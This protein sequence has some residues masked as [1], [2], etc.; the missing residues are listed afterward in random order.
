[1]STINEVLFG[2]LSS[3]SG[4]AALLAANGIT[5]I[6]HQ[7]PPQNPTF[8]YVTYQI[9]SGAPDYHLNG[10]TTLFRNR[11]EINVWAK[12]SKSVT[13]VNIAIR[14]SLTAVRG[15]VN[16][17]LVYGVF[18]ERESDFYESDLKIFRISTDYFFHYKEQML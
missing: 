13:D 5:R 7:V 14:K 8:P 1:M 6:Y 4:V 3:D 10:Q 15:M 17:T 9:I 18:L 11:I 16:D 2:R 12:N